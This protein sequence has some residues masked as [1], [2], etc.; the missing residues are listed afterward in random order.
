MKVTKLQLRQIIKEE[1]KGVLDEQK[2]IHPML[3]KFLKIQ[4]NSHKI[5]TRDGSEM[6]VAQAIKKGQP[7]ED[8]FDEF[9]AAWQQM[10]DKAPNNKM[11][12]RL[13]I[14][15]WLKKSKAYK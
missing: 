10:Y 5:K 12:L 9:I 15:G 8:S 3:I 14:S 2:K 7:L 1:L 11:N 4:L 6:T 13:A